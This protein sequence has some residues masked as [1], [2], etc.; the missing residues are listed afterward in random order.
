[1]VT[2]PV[3]ALPHTSSAALHHSFVIYSQNSAA[4]AVSL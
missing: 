3:A 2:V 4:P 1:M